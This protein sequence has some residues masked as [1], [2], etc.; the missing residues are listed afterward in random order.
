M[1]FGQPYKRNVSG[2][3]E[4]ADTKLVALVSSCNFAGYTEFD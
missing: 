2:R 3:K 1:E 4:E